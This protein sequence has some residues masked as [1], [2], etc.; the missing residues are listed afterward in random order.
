M[1]GRFDGLS[2]NQWELLSTVFPDEEKFSSGRGMPRVPLRKALNSLLYILF[3]GS[4]WCD[5]P[6]GSQ[7]AS[8]SSSHRAVKRWG[9]NGILLLVFQKLLSVADASDLINWTSGSV[10]GSFSPWERRRKRS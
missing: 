10:D 7:W 9:E 5:L 4:R 8:K 6:R 2:N 1:A 3:T